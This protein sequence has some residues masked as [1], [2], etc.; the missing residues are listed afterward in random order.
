MKSLSA[1]WASFVFLT[2]LK[3]ITPGTE[4]SV[5][6]HSAPR[7][8]WAGVGGM[9]APFPRHLREDRVTVEEAEGLTYVNGSSGGDPRDSA[10]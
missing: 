7:A 8:R 3:L 1:G 2:Q 4:L 6:L 9:T 5:N 10:A